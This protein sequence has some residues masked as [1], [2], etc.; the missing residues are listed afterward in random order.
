M[1]R[2]IAAMAI[3]GCALASSPS[4]AAP[5]VLEAQAPAPKQAPQT[6]APTRPGAPQP[7]AASAPAVDPA[8]VAALR[9]MGEHLVSLRS[10]EIQTT[11]SIEYVL[12]NNQK[13]L[14][15]GT[16][17]YR[18]RRP[19]RLRVDLTTDT[20]DRVFQYDGKQL[21]VTAPKEKFFARLDAKPTVRETLSWVAQTF[22]VEV[23]LADLFD[24][25][26][27]DA[28]EGDIREGFRIGKALV[29]GV[30]CDHWAF[31]GADVDWEVWIRAGDSP[32]PLKLSIVTTADTV[33]P[34]YEAVLSW[35]EAVEFP[36]DIFVHA[37]IADA[38]RIEFL[39][40]APVQGQRK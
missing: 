19:D 39:P 8:A 26:T 28:P 40:I 29:G 25:G 2:A 17:H 9:R 15:G 6:K 12:E 33:R 3:A 24:W 14:I 11:I 22:G 5:D 35:S 13:I 37:P 1:K 30:E 27:P 18:V 34:R 21:V 16:S 20:L 10:F 23:P 4:A 31:R 36:D 38:K 32:L 7:P